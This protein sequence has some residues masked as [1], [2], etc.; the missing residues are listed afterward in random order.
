MGTGSHVVLKESRSHDR[1]TMMTR[2]TVSGI[3]SNS[4]RQGNNGVTEKDV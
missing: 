3:I 2:L 1:E 4:G